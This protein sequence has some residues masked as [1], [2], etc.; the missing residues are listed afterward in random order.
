MMTVVLRLCAVK[1]RGSGFGPSCRIPNLPVQCTVSAAKKTC[2]PSKHSKLSNTGVQLHRSNRE[3]MIHS[4]LVPRSQDEMAV[5]LQCVTLL[6]LSNKVRSIIPGLYNFIYVQFFLDFVIR[7]VCLFLSSC[8]L[9]E[10]C[11]WVLGYV[12]TQGG[13]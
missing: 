6:K 2:T 3:M 13:V 7:F 11:T 1:E 4:L 12:F 10:N 5:H 8:A 9:L